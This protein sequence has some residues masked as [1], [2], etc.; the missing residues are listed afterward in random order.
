MSKDNISRLWAIESAL[1]VI[2]DHL[3]SNK[4][5]TKN[6]IIGGMKMAL[7]ELDAVSD[8]LNVYNSKTSLRDKI[9]DSD[10]EFDGLVQ[11]Y[12]NNKLLSY[13]PIDKQSEV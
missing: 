6:C 8:E 10:I 4:P 1:E 3:Y 9:I 13:K 11:R 7:A 5:V 2:Y 12:K